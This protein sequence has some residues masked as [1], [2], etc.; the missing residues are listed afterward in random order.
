[1]KV[2][3]TLVRGSHN[4]TTHQPCLL[5]VYGAY[6]MS[7]EAGYNAVD[8]LLVKR[9]WTLAFAHVRGGGELGRR[10]HHA[11]RQSGKLLALQVPQSVPHSGSCS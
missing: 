10:W 1:M 6:G 9:G 8:T 2:P 3:L 4:A 5:R 11:G 7:L